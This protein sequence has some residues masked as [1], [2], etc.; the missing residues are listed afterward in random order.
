MKVLGSFLT[1]ALF[2][3]LVSCSGTKYTVT[4]RSQP[5]VA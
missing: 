2:A 4:T 5:T 1:V 3:T